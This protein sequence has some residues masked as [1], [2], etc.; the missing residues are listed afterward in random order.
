MK[1]ITKTTERIPENPDDPT[2][3]EIFRK[4]QLK[5]A[6][7]I[8]QQGHGTGHSDTEVST[9]TYNNRILYILY[10][11]DNLNIIDMGIRIFP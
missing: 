10:N 2:L 8:L 11:I 9:C 4:I 7:F 6:N 1:V 3:K 5:D